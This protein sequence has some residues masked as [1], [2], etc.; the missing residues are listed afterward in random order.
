M[1]YIEKTIELWVEHGLG[2]ARHPFGATPFTPSARGAILGKILVNL[3]ETDLPGT[4]WLD[5]V[6]NFINKNALKLPESLA[7]VDA[8]TELLGGADN[9][10]RLFQ[11]SP[12]VL[13][14]IWLDRLGSKHAEIR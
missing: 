5:E 11:D 7:T 6:Y 3:S 14:Y 1:S 12:C 10:E 4:P 8:P 9:A 13:N 2:V